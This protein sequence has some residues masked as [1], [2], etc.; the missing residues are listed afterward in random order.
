MTDRLSLA[1]FPDVEAGRTPA[2][3]ALLDWVQDRE[4]ERLCLVSGAAG[5]G[6][7]HLLAWSMGPV[8]FDAMVPGEGL[9]LAEA[10]WG[11][12]GQLCYDGWSVDDLLRHVTQDERPLCIVVADAHKLDN[13]GR[14]PGTMLVPEVL[15]PL[16]E[17]PWV[18]VLAEVRDAK[19]SPFTKPARVIDLDDPAMTD[20]GEYTRWYNELAGGR[21]S[22]PV[23]EVF[24]HPVSGQ[25]AASL[26]DSLPEGK[27]VCTAWWESLGAPVRGAMR[28]LALA[29]GWMGVATWRLLH[30]GLHPHDPDAADA[31]DEAA[32]RLTRRTVEYRLPLPRLVSLARREDDSGEQVPDPERVFEILL[33]LVPR[34]RNGRPDWEHAPRYVLDHILA[35]APEPR[36]AGELI[37]DPGFLVHAEAGAITRAL[38]DAKVP[39]PPSLRAAW[40]PAA[41]TLY[42]EAYDAPRTEAQRAAV[43]RTS[44]LANAPRLADLLAPAARGSGFIARW[45]LPRR[46]LPVLDGPVPEASWPGAVAAMA[47]GAEGTVIAADTLGQLRRL[48]TAD[49]TVAGRTVNTPATGASG[50]VRIGDD[51][52]VLLDTSGTLRAVGPVDPALQAALAHHNSPAGGTRAVCLGGDPGGRT[53]V[54]GDA[55]GTVHLH[56]AGGGE[57]VTVRISE[58]PLT[59]VGCLRLGNGADLVLVGSADGHLSVWAPPRPPLDQAFMMDGSPPTA[60]ALAETRVGVVYAAAYTHRVISVGRV[61]YGSS[62][63]IHVPHDIA[64]LVLT[65]DGMLAAAGYDGITCWR[66]DLGALP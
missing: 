50:L 7:S 64:A 48:S 23:G 4:A 63:K 8:R 29:R 16:L 26:P 27:D 3:Q 41:P 14:A 5:A 11:I 31:V 9:R 47:P 2:C 1:R 66:C 25:L 22:V 42:G 21:P 58:V 10:V 20:E 56:E 12:S 40:Y 18:R 62:R 35:H 39:T 44:A 34:D 65:P 61:E 17:L 49:G 53:L 46:S 54:V 59:A 13:R 15:E 6:K 37:S 32:A 36:M 51:T 33:G 55:A 52:F 43:L 28:T 19:A 60:I 57:P 30:A 38:E 24:P 45:S